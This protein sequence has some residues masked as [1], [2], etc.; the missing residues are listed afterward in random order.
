M[1]SLR[2][3][4]LLNCD[5]DPLYRQN[6][7]KFDRNE[8]LTANKKQFESYV[9]YFQSIQI[10]KLN[11]EA[12]LFSTIFTGKRYAKAKAKSLKSICSVS[13]QNHV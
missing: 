9:M 8:N 3:F 2:K 13:S 4:W 5:F 11:L 6:R 12:K 7:L 1:T 10:K